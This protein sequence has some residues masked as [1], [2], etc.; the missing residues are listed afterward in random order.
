MS[1]EMGDG[2]DGGGEAKV[3]SSPLLVSRAQLSPERWP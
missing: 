2:K 1:Y 3:I